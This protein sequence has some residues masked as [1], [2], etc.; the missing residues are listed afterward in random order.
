MEDTIEFG[1]AVPFRFPCDARSSSDKWSSIEEAGRDFGSAVV[2][3]VVV[4]WLNAMEVCGR[5]P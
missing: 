1:D 5:F 3:R 2:G 4:D